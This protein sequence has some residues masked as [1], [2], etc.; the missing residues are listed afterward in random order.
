LPSV[1]ASSLDGKEGVDGS[2]PS[3][4]FPRFPGLSR[5]SAANRR[6]TKLANGLNVDNT[7]VS[8]GAVSHYLALL[9]AATGRHEQAE[10]HFEDALALNNRMGARPWL[11]HTQHEYGRMLAERGR[12]ERA[13]ELVS[14]A[15][16]TYRDLGMNRFAAKATTL[17]RNSA[18]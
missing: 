11:A 14:A 18:A 1:P 15:L 3:E 6:G 4:G 17:V 16:A 8:T 9:S 10:R 7:E 13:H 2:S 12:T 5:S